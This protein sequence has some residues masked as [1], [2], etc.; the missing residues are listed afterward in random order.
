MNLIMP[1]AL[2][3]VA[4]AGGGLDID[5]ANRIL[6]PDTMEKIARAAAAS[7][8]K[9]TITFRNVAIL[10]PDVAKQI[11]RAGQGCVVFVV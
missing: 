8:K 5:C 2:I 1:D 3:A 7:G 10:L 11:A 9:P 4:A 6:L